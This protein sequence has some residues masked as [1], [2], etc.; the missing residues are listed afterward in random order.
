MD[1]VMLTAISTVGFPIVVTF[2]LLAKFQNT[3]DNFSNKVDELLQELRKGYYLQQNHPPM[4]C[5]QMKG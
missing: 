3:M 5:Q 2:Y 1:D 4:S